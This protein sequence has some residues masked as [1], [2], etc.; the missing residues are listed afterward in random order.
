MNK[1]IQTRLLAIV[2]VTLACVYL[3]AGFPPSLANMRERINLGLDLR[4]GTH[5]VLQVVTDDAIKA[6]TDRSIETLRARLQQ[7]GI[8]FRQLNPTSTNTYAAIGV[9][10]G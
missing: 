3:F 7:E 4:G 9:D 10:A 6:E 2:V 1:R 8:T 5:L